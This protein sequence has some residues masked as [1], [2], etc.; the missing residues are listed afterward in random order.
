MARWSIQTYRRYGKFCTL[1][2]YD[3]PFHLILDTL[4]TTSPLI[5]KALLTWLTESFTFHSLSPAERAAAGQSLAKPRG[6][7]YGI[8]LAVALFAM[9]GLSVFATT[10]LCMVFTLSNLQKSQVWQLINTP[11]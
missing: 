8:G 10:R 2:S 3:L 6:I 1:P 4:Q 7:G 9:Q 11:Y 5:S